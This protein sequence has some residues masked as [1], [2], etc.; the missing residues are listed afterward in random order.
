MNLKEA[1]ERLRYFIMDCDCLA[2]DN[3][4]VV[5]WGNGSTMDITILQ[6][7]Y[8]Y[9]GIEVPWKFWSVNDVRTIVDLNPTI[10]PKTK[11]NTGVQHSA[12]GDC[13]HEIKYLVNT[14]KTLR[15]KK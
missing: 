8:E 6:S 1:L 7:A 3:E 5:V 10:K 13:L 11:F 12:V 15:I 2:E 4:N 14:L 9:F